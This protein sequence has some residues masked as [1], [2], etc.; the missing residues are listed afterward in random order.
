MLPRA[1][2]NRLPKVWSPAEQWLMNTTARRFTPG[3]FFFGARVEL[4]RD[5]IY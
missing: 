4:G 3:G 1:G 2:L 5:Q